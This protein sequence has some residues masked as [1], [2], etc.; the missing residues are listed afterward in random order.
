VF[1]FG[2]VGAGARRSAALR[3]LFAS[4]AAAFAITAGL[5]VTPGSA[6]ATVRTGTVVAQLLGVSCQSG[7]CVA[8]GDQED[9]TGVAARGWRLSAG[10]WSVARA[11]STTNT[12]PYL[13]SVSCTSSG[14]CIAVG[15]TVGYGL[16]DEFMAGHWNEMFLPGATQPLSSVSCASASLCIAVGST[17]T[18][19]VV[20][21]E[22]LEWNGADWTAQVTPT[23]P[24]GS[25]LLGVSCRSIDFC[26]AVGYS[27]SSMLAEDWNGT[28][29]SV[30]SPP[31]SMVSESWYHVNAVACPTTTRCL[32]V[33][34]SGGCCSSY[35]SVT[36]SWNGSS[37]TTI[38]SPTGSQISLSGISCPS[39]SACMAVGSSGPTDNSVVPMEPL[40]WRW[41]AGSWVATSKLSYGTDGWLGAISCTRIGWCAAVGT[42]QT[43]ASGAA[44]PLA[45]RWNGTAMARMWTPT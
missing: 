4:V 41:G 44:T 40:A 18:N 28:S 15:G 36:L 27:E 34:A 35:S 8:T 29:W 43:S 21:P 38:G 20:E 30:A 17:E 5:M 22:V 25:A 24:S 42:Y 7:Q 3:R 19:G 32:A 45:L 31:P 2:R 1:S 23:T 12:H 37:W 33:G 26:M 13:A 10:K 39:A 14:T 11:P 16:A 6:G 9:T